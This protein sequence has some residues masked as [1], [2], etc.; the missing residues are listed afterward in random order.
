MPVKNR[1]PRT[2]SDFTLWFT[3]EIDSLKEHLASGRCQEYVDYRAVVGQITGLRA[4]QAEW[5]AL[6]SSQEEEE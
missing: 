1:S 6:V 5:L 4:A 2:E 3:A